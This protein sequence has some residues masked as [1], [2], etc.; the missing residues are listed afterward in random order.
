MEPPTAN[1]GVAEAEMCRQAAVQRQER[2][3]AHAGY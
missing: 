2:K 1:S 3:N